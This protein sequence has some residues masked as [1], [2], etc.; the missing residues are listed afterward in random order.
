MPVTL[1]TVV[2]PSELLAHLNNLCGGLHDIDVLSLKNEMQHYYM[3][4]EGIP[5]YVNALKDVHKRSKRFGNPITKDTQVIIAINTMLSTECFPQV[6][7]I[8]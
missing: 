6:D 4:M 3:D 1:Y 7:E 5:K 2:S 8:G